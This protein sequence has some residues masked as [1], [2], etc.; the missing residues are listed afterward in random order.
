MKKIFVLLFTSIL[1]QSCN[2]GDII[3]TNF[4]FE[5]AQLQQCGEGDTVVFFKINP[6]VNESI[7]LLLETTEDLFL[8]TGTQSFNLI[9]SGSRVNY[10]G[11]DATVTESYFCNPIPPTTPLVTIEYLGTSGTAQLISLTIL[12]DNDGIA[13]VDSDSQTEEGFGDFD[14]DGI[15]NY[16]DFDDDGD[17]VPTAVEIGEDPDNPRDSD[18]DGM[19]DYLDRDDDND[20]VLT[21]NEDINGNLNPA[22]DIDEA[23]ALPNYLDDTKT[24]EVST[25]EYRAH[26]FNRTSDGSIIIENLVLV[27]EEEEII[28][29]TFDFGT[30]NG[31]RDETITITPDF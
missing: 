22:D 27:N 2:D 4:D 13:F 11:F 17:N 31:V 15:P 26:F 8:E 25:L 3:V 29:E 21:I 30:I 28:L 14:V 16:Y 23:G 20:G 10:R 18:M 19:A 5:D 9:A 6:D 1:F 7:S 24:D 12:E